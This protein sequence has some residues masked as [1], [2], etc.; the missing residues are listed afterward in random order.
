MTK[1][2]ELTRQYLPEL[3][4]GQY[5]RLG[6]IGERLVEVN[7]SL[8]LTALTA[9]EEVALLH[10][11][12]SLTLL[13]TGLFDGAYSVLDVGCGGGFPSL[14]LAACTDCKITSNDATLK[15]LNFV[16]ETAKLAGMEITPLCGRAEELGKEKA[17]REQF[18]RV[19]SRG[20][21]RMS[22]LCEWCLPFVK[23]GGYFVAMKGNRG[24]E[25]LEEAMNAIAV[26]GGKVVDVVDAPIPVFERDHT[27]LVIQKVA[28][29][30]EK[31]P[32]PNGKI[33]KKPL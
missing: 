6:V 30:D 26:L 7:Q 33:M 9:P 22:V 5:A 13:K 4:E 12:D 16:S 21:A 20:V 24:R 23:V 14:P 31:Y 25:E 18:D 10:F 19:V 15:K 17:Y 32:R 1:L 27:L 11:Y 3:T 28:E 2:N 29:T 8:N